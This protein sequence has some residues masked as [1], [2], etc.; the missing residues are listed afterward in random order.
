MSIELSARLHASRRTPLAACVGAIF[1]LAAPAAY[2]NTFVIN[3]NDAGVGSLRGAVAIAAEDDIVDASG[4]TTASPGCSASTIT[5]TTGDI[6]ITQNDLTIQGPG[7]TALT[8]TGKNGAVTQHSRI[9]THK[10]AIVGS[11]TLGIFDLTMSNGYAASVAGN[12]KGG[13]IY[14]KGNV[15]LKYAGVYECTAKTKSTYITASAS[16]GGI[17]TIGYTELFASTISL[18]VADAGYSTIGGGGGV[19]SRGAFISINSSITNNKATNI[20][21]MDG[22]GGGVTSLGDRMTIAGSTI[23]RNHADGNIGGLGLTNSTGTLTIVNSTISGNSAKGIIGGIYSQNLKA[24]FLNSTIAFNTA[25]TG[26]SSNVA[27][28]LLAAPVVGAT[29]R[30]ESTLIANN[31][32]GSPAAASDIGG[33]IVVSG[34]HNLVRTPGISL[35]SDTI[36]GK[37]PLLGPLKNN[38]GATMTHALLS[39][40]PAIDKGNNL[41]DQTNDQRDS[42]YLRTSGIAP[43]IGAYEVDQADKIFDTDFEGCS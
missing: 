12:A 34:S 11:G 7:R 4:L 28:L 42:P 15:S 6:V 23:A 30:M 13:C 16:G 39:R 24:Y 29:A 33:N 26:T 5:L 41:Y 18:N 35:P 37:C 32:Y 8:V 25:G 19:Y 36:V 27:G 9:F 40:S 22:S 14:S 21:K 1:A 2:A 31:S 10:P 38:G 43:D 17:Y 20:A 3:C